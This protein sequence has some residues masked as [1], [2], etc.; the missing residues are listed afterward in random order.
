[1][2]DSLQVLA[3]SL[4]RHLVWWFRAFDFGHHPAAPASSRRLVFLLLAY[5]LF[6]CLQAVHWIGLLADECFFRG[7]RQVTVRRPVFIT[8]VPRSGT[9][10]L[11]RTL[12]ADR[13]RFTSLATW[14]A[15]LA[16]SITER[17]CLTALASLDRRLG[18]FA[19]RGLDAALRC[20]CGDF[21]KIHPVS[22]D[23]PEEDYLALLPAGGCFL[24]ALA[25]PS[26][27]SL[28]GLTRLD[29]APPGEQARLLRFY[30]AL[31]QRHLYHHGASRTL[32]SKNAAFASWVPALRETFPDARFLICVREPTEALSSQLS[33]LHD[34][35]RLFGIDPSGR[36]VVG[37]FT[38]L[39]GHLYALVASLAEEEKSAALA[40]VAQCDLAA[41]P[42]STIRAAL[43]LADIDIHGPLEAALQ[44]LRAHPGSAHRHGL[45]E[46]TMHSREIQDCARPAYEA[47]LRSPKCARPD[48]IRHD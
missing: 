48:S 22:L 36:W 5:P 47:I 16:P 39:W 10:F 11:H 21:D 40:I 20:V 12:A 9:T 19:R 6:L 18:G 27:R 35:R 17:K 8:G 2:P 13:E 33:S 45:T 34:A 42:R 7:Y 24:L 3:L 15:V 31:L 37:E 41:D 26:S 1:M 29:Q 23:A 44:R 28:W 43:K 46:E 14:E 38:R 4:R 25:F 30:R 32:L